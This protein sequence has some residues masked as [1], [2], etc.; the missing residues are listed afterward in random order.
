MI[1]DALIPHA[2]QTS[3]EPGVLGTMQDGAIQ[4]LLRW[5]HVVAGVLWIGLLYFFNWVNGPFEGKLDGPT[6]KI[7]VP[8]LRPR[9]LFFFRW[10][11]AYTWISGLLLVGLLYY[12]AKPGTLNANF[13][14]AGADGLSGQSTVKSLIALA[15][16]VLLFPVYDLIAKSLSKSPMAGLWVWYVVALGYAAFLQYWMKASD[17]ATF[18]HVGALFGTMMAANVWMRIWPNQKRIIGA[19]KGGTAPDAAWVGMAGLRS[20]HNTFMSMPLLLLMISVHMTYML[21]QHQA[22]AVIAGS[23]VIAYLVTDWIYKAAAKVPGM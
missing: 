14:G 8:E 17:R 4:L 16:V 7:V 10:G 22:T 18:I 15:L 19:I 1:A 9:A 12:H 6:K 13:W 21:G 2:I 23:L 20:K 3:S 11:A 5:I